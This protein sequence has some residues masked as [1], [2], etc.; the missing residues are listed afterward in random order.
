VIVRQ[1]VRHLSRLQDVLQ[2]LTQLF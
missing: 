2:V 1:L